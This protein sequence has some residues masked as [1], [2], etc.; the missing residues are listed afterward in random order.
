M[1]SGVVRYGR[2][3]EVACSLSVR[4]MFLKQQ[5]AALKQQ[6]R[7]VAHRFEEAILAM[8]QPKTFM[9][10]PDYTQPP[11]R[12]ITLG[13]LLM[14]SRDTGLPDPDLPLNKSSRPPINDNDIKRSTEEPW[15]FEHSSG[16]SKTGSID[17]QVP[18]FAPVGGSF[19][20]GR[21]KSVDFVV[22]CNRLE[23]E[24]F[25]PSNQ[26]LSKALQDEDVQHYCRQYFFPSVY[27]VTGIKIAHEAGIGGRSAV[28][29]HTS[30]SAWVDTTSVGV[31]LQAGP[32]TGVS[33]AAHAVSR[34]TILEPFI[35]AYQLKRLKLR[36]DGSLRKAES[37]N[38][39]ALFDDSNETHISSDGDLGEWSIEDVVPTTQHDA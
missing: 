15:Y 23:T 12:D 21:S 35:L 29:G 39:H 38:K 24:R 6:P 30:V 31:P 22:T 19:A 2:A 5:G 28:A 8:A 1:S 9:L 11:N 16:N 25:A 20:L 4:F 13:T 26:Y 7:P 18:V 27:M 34:T 3:A 32:A 17:A 14:L 10:L 37:F 36:R 33:S